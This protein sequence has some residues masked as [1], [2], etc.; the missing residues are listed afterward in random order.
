MPRTITPEVIAS[1]P[2][3]NPTNPETRGPTKTI[4][5]ALIWAVATGILFLRLYTRRCISH[6]MGWD[7]YLVTSA[8]IPA[9]AFSVVGIAM[10]HASRW[11]RHIWD[12]TPEWIAKGLQLR[13]AGFALFDL[14]TTLT[15][16]S[17]LVLIHRLTKPTSIHLRRFILALVVLNLL[18]MIT[19]LYLILLQCR[20]LSSYVAVFSSSRQC[21][22]EG[23][24]LLIAGIWNTVMDAVLVLLPL[25]I[26][27]RSIS[28]PRPQIAVVIFL[29]A[30][31]GL[32]SVA[33]AV[34]TYLLYVQSTALD[35]DF[36][37]RSGPSYLAGTVELYLG[38]VCVSIPATRLFFARLV[39]RLVDHSPTT[40]NKSDPEVVSTLSERAYSIPPQSSLAPSSLPSSERAAPDL[41][42]ALPPLETTDKSQA[43]GPRS[44]GMTVD[45]PLRISLW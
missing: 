16:L 6:R 25:V 14:A 43:W 15:K 23:R 36:T 8:Y 4:L 29:F 2:A 40:N 22:D 13:L 39:P 31:G 20:P 27:I 1:W 26:V 32:V 37:W 17:I 19:Y 38:I 28:L 41:N 11:N 7:D 35:Y 24:S 10:D 21:S 12:L 9:T 18:G 44:S 42:K 3:P 34:R 33:G 30:M 45:M 5:T